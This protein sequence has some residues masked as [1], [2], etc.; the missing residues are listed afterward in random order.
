MSPVA[1]W[2]EARI[3]IVILQIPA[4]ICISNLDVWMDTVFPI[5]ISHFGDIE[6]KT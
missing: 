5:R 3:Q 2:P 6:N 1:M 4:E